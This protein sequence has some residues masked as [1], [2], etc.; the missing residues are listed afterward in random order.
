MIDPLTLQQAQRPKVT[1]PAKTKVVE[2][3]EAPISIYFFFNNPTILKLTSV[4]MIWAL[5]LRS[6]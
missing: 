1:E 6:I 5:P 4:K 2:P 3:V